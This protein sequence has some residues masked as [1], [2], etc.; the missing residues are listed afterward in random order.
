M[1]LPLS[2]GRSLTLHS[3][4]SSFPSFTGPRLSFPE[5]GVLFVLIVPILPSS[6]CERI[7]RPRWD[8]PAVNFWR[9]ALPSE[10]KV[11]ATRH[12]ALS[13]GPVPQAQAVKV[14]AKPL[15]TVHSAFPRPGS[16]PLL[17]LSPSPGLSLLP[18]L[19]LRDFCCIT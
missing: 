13:Q 17:S 12:R 14:V 11:P 7:R 18:S 4:T 1:V 15:A 19:C 2:Q 3:D 9:G 10:E 8:A 16:R 5:P 6:K